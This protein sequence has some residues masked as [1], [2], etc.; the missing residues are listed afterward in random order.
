MSLE[1]KFEELRKRNVLAMEGGGKKRIETQHAQ[2]KLTARERVELLL[3]P[4]SFVELDRFVQHRCADFEMEKFLG[5]GVITG[6]GQVNGRLVY[7]FAQDFTV[8]GGSL[9]EAYAEKICKIMDHAVR[10]G[11]PVVGLN[12]SGGARIQEGVQSLAGYADIFLR[13]TLSSGVVPQISAIMGPC[14]GGAVYSPAITDFNIMVEGTSYMFVTG[15]DVIRTV[16]HE[17]VTK[18]QLGGA[19]THNAT[20][21]VAHF[22][23]PDDRT[24]LQLIRE[25]LGY[26]PSNNLDE[27]PV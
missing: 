22:A 26:L 23:V 25:L 3:D 24:C 8:Y 11:A 14:A 27:A 7:V 9:S 19:M 2:G 10:N 6:Y 12:D 17:E 1:K 21:G 15:P 18:E 13:N 20:S 16:T 5:D 4:N